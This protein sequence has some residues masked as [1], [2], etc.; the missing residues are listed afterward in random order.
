M[1][2]YFAL[3]YI[4]MTEPNIIKHGNFW[5]QKEGFGFKDGIIFLQ[6]VMVPN[7]GVMIVLGGDSLKFL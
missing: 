7:D 1:Q 3:S 4:S 5:N 2:L 6:D